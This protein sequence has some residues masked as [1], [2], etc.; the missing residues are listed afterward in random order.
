MSFIPLRDLPEERIFALA[1]RLDVRG[2]RYTSYPTVPVW[3]DGFPPEVFERA[4]EDLGREGQPFA[5]YVHLPFCRQRCLYCGCNS[6]ITHQQDRMAGYMEALNLELERVAQKLPAGA[7]HAQLHLGGGTPTYIPAPLLAAFLDRLI[8]L[9]PGAPAAERSIEVDPRVTTDEVLH[10]LAQRGFR[11]ISAGLQDLNPEVQKAVN[12]VFTFE[13]MENFTAQARR[14]G[15]TGVNIDL[16]YGLPKQTRA[17]WAATLE[18]VARLHPD[19]LA[20][21]GYAH[22]PAKIRHQQALREEDLPAPRERLGMLLDAHTF[23]TGAGWE[24]V[25][26]DHFA[27]PEDDLARA[28]R[29]GRLWRNFM[30]YTTGRGLDLLGLGCSAISEFETSFVQN[31]TPP[32]EYAQAL[33]AG[34]WA[35]HR[36]HLMDAEDRLRKRIITQLMC[37]LEIALPDEA[38]AVHCGLAGSLKQAMESLR[39]FEADG[40]IVARNGGYEVTPLGQLFLRNLAMPFDGYLPR[41]GGSTFSRTV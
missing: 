19:R 34:R 26:F 40:L 8:A 22:L 21:F 6:Y 11:R 38:S 14:A 4:V 15:F 36:G 23:F 12:R 9:I 5:V 30:G 27:R 24:A 10:L 13:Q 7:R 32:E 29:E 28:R 18:A 39:P 25:G 17:T 41:Q 2:P 33:R 37:N 1:E 31:I 16:I 20:C 3:R 35:A